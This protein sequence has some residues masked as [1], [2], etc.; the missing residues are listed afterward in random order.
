MTDF[1]ALYQ[2][3]RERLS[4]RVARLDD[5]SAATP[6]DA[7]PGW[8]V[9]GV[10]SHLVGIV[11]DLQSGNL[12]GVGSDA[13]TG[14]QVDAR[15]DAS[16]ADIVAEWNDKAPAL[17]EQLA[18]WPPD[19]AGQLVSDVTSHELDVLGALGIRDGRDSDAVRYTCARYAGGLGTRVTE[20]GLAPL[21]VIADGETVLPGGDAEAEP[22][23]TVRASSFELARAAS[24]RRSA[25]Q[26]RAFDWDGDPEPYLAV[27]SGYG[28]R[29]TDL[30]E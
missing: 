3:T 12:E 25:D 17:E 29:A 26:I 30:V 14:A 23:A 5:A 4:A 16:L 20:A 6:V 27:F 2:E 21:V 11:S 10:V 19:V 8:D 15:R 13:W 1:A 24:G 22:A 28:A 9:K 7:C 18:T